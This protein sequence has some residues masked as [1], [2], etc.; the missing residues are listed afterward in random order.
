M[1]KLLNHT[2]FAKWPNLLLIYQ[3]WQWPIS[4]RSTFSG[5][6]WSLGV[7]MYILLCGYPPF[8]GSCGSICGWNQGESCNACQELLFHSIQDGQFEFPNT[9]WAGISGAAKD[10]ICKLLVKDAR[11]RLSAEMVL[12]HP[13]LKTGGSPA[14]LLGKSLVQKLSI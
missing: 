5:D 2:S 12:S 7:I 1:E 11:R 9:E 10:L 4:V 14:T 13:W 6:L 8:S 3:P